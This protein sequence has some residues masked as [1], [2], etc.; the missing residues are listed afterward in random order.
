MNGHVCKGR[1]GA[2]AAH[3]GNTRICGESV[4]RSDPLV[5]GRDRFGSS[6]RPAEGAVLPGGG[7]PGGGQQGVQPG[8]SCGPG[9][10]TS[11]S[12]SCARRSAV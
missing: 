4:T 7:Q 1:S 8:R 3:A 2:G 11:R 12:G 6:P 5:S 10:L 9:A